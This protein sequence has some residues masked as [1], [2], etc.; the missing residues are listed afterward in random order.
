[1]DDA[2]NTE[3]FDPFDT[4]TDPVSALERICESLE[5]H[6]FF[7]NEPE[8]NRDTLI[9]EIMPELSEMKDILSNNTDSIVALSSVYLKEFSSDL[10]AAP[11]DEMSAILK[12]LVAV[13]GEMPVSDLMVQRVDEAIEKISTTN[14]VNNDPEI[15]RGPIMDEIRSLVSDIRATDVM[16]SGNSEWGNIENTC[17]ETISG[18]LQSA[19]EALKERIA[20]TGDP[21]AV[22]VYGT[23]QD[24]NIDRETILPNVDL[25]IR[26]SGA[27]TDRFGI[28]LDGRLAASVEDVPRAR[29]DIAAYI[30]A[31]NDTMRS[32]PDYRLIDSFD[33]PLIQDA[34]TMYN[35][36][37]LY[38]EEE[39]PIPEMDSALE[40]YAE[41]IQKVY[42]VDLI[43]REKLQ[44]ALENA[45][46]DVS[47]EEGVERTSGYHAGGAGDIP[48]VSLE[49]V[50]TKDE[51]P[52]V[53]TTATEDA[54][55][56]AMHGRSI[57]WAKTGDE[58]IDRM[59]SRRNS[60]IDRSALIPT[61]R[62]NPVYTFTE[63]QIVFTAAAKG[64]PVNG[65]VPSGMECLVAY[66]SFLH[67]NLLEF[68]VL[69]VL[70][71]VLD[72]VFG[73]T[74]SDN[75]KDVFLDDKGAQEKFDVAKIED[76]VMRMASNIQKDGYTNVQT[77]RSNTNIS[78]ETRNAIADYIKHGAT[79]EK[80]GDAVRMAYEKVV[81]SPQFTEDTVTLLRT[82]FY[83]AG[84]EGT[85]TIEGKE[86]D[87]RVIDEPSGSTETAADADGKQDD[88]AAVRD[89]EDPQAR[90][91]PEDAADTA[92]AE[93]ASMQEEAE[94][95]DTQDLD[96]QDTDIPEREEPEDF[97]D[98]AAAQGQEPD[99]DI[100][101]E[102]LQNDLSWDNADMEDEEDWI[103]DTD[104]LEGYDEPEGFAGYGDLT[105]EDDDRQ[106][107]ADT[108]KD[109]RDAGLETDIGEAAAADTTDQI[110]P[111]EMP[112]DLAMDKEPADDG[113]DEEVEAQAQPEE[114]EIESDTDEHGL[115]GDEPVFAGDTDDMDAEQ[116]ARGETPPADKDK[117]EDDDK[118]DV[119]TAAAI[120]ADTQ[121][122][123]QPELKEEVDIS[124]GE[125]A[126]A[127]P[128]YTD[129]EMQEPSDSTPSVKEVA[130][131]GISQYVSEGDFGFGDL[132]NL[133]VGTED[134]PVTL[135][136]A[137]FSGDLSDSDVAGFIAEAMESYMNP[138]EENDDTTADDMIADAF[139]G[140]ID[141]FSN[142]MDSDNFAGMVTEAMDNLHDSDQTDSFHASVL[143]KVLE[144]ALPTE[145]VDIEFY[146]DDPFD[147]ME[148]TLQQNAMDMAGMEMDAVAADNPGLTDAGLE[149]NSGMPDMVWENPT[150]TSADY[151]EDDDLTNRAATQYDG[152]ADEDQGIDISLDDFKMDIQMPDD[153]PVTMPEDDSSTIQPV[154]PA[155]DASYN[156]PLLSDSEMD[157]PDYGYDAQQD[158]DYDVPAEFQDAGAD[159]TIDV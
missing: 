147:D 91:E 23:D 13:G 51:T 20:Q 90:T 45:F 82:V 68:A 88:E 37:D 78:Y 122:K 63:M 46:N 25:A 127:G 61:Y 2:V 75:P 33:L 12:G 107:D 152:M 158:F 65:K 6:E 86:I 126:D 21:N 77:G 123:E 134:E 135:G 15:F 102:E 143:D 154:D 131:D 130:L 157:D 106:G 40:K 125:T 11:A 42:G 48:P 71:S 100:Y 150:D 19:P 81:A 55:T 97:S 3:S 155:Y 17:R 84:N 124:S 115:T 103:G 96:T 133:N 24:G 120:S 151:L 105:Q 49:G 32:D 114:Q 64:V 72:V 50:Y 5:S 10:S 94:N 80:A 67:T 99:F 148:Q 29:E 98:P 93:P 141:N 28:T 159:Y 4:D 138:E 38:D 9:N 104:T 113:Q 7:D 132:L 18:N 112:E 119:M 146:E 117:D 70:G 83:N 116:A 140:L 69:S 39:G 139:A 136:E 87:F 47:A 8:L 111:E 62:M 1:M 54:G 30:G 16:L 44:D 149:A 108:S 59:I 66:N 35:N 89:K 109:D 73:N 36:G 156:D 153:S 76:G 118:T 31:L 27:Y 110:Q 79:E 58:G 145:A 14:I 144:N 60:L 85:V 53:T 95:L 142:I 101:P 121:E 92:E 74:D 128:G 57:Q 52:P 41:A 34:I 137:V 26:D 43:D 56:A 22:F 129:V